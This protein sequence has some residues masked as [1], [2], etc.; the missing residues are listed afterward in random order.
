MSH[1]TREAKPPRSAAWRIEPGPGFRSSLRDFRSRLNGFT[2]STGVFPPL[3]LMFTFSVLQVQLLSAA[4]VDTST[5]VAWVA[6][7]WSAGGV[8]GIV[9]SL[10]YKMPIAGA[11]S[12]PGFTFVGGLLGTG[13]TTVSEA[14]GAFWMSG[15]VVLLL[16][17]TGLMKAVVRLLP[18]PV[19][20]AMIAGILI[21]F[22]I[23]M[24]KELETQAPIVIAGIVGYVIVARLGG[25]F[26]RIPGVVGTI[27][28]GA[29]AAGVT[30]QL[31]FS[32]FQF[33]FG[34]VAFH[35]PTFTMEAFLTIALPLALMVVGAENMQAIGI[36]KASGHRP[37]I[38]AATVISGLG[39]L[40]ASAFGSENANLAGPT[41][42]VMNSED[43][44]PHDGRYVAATLSGV[45]YIV[46][47]ILAGTVVSL[48]AALP[49]ALATTLLGM[50]LISVVVVTIKETWESGR[51]VVG[52]FFAFV[53]ALAN[54]PFFGIGAPFWA[55]VG[56]AVVA[57][58]FEFKDYILMR[59]HNES[60][61]DAIETENL[62]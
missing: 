7:S 33:G 50:V 35:T 51:F 11:W 27:I 3:V 44:G 57:A 58:L 25:P 9:L 40:V 61:D 18:T 24:V 31:D 2:I 62:R 29:V 20:L 41:T 16:G 23:D 48:I 14:F 17:V 30:G 10:F 1:N 55:L 38:T 46:L 5:I 54:I 15:A 19:I 49:G 53:I 34:Q 60:G 59:K 4:N 13:D 37:P 45:T 6:V 39:G 32:G 52:A 36:L 42:A 56:G 12:I 26:R 22:P 28:L 47:G 21:K 43:A 8:V